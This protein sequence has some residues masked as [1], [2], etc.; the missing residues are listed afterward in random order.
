MVAPRRGMSLFTSWGGFESF[1]DGPSWEQVIE[2]VDWS[3]VVIEAEGLHERRVE[4]DALHVRVVTA[5]RT[6][7]QTCGTCLQDV[8]LD[9][10]WAAEGKRDQTY[11]SA[12]DYCV[13]HACSRVVCRGAGRVCST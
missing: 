8:L 4:E 11:P 12:E 6:A 3:R 13:V 1:D 10:N 9:R 2:A 5:D 7:P